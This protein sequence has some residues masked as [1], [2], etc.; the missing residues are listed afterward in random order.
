VSQ[1]WECIVDPKDL[2]AAGDI[3]AFHQIE[4]MKGPV[5][6]DVKFKEFKCKKGWRLEAVSEEI[7]LNEKNH[8]YR[9]IKDIEKDEIK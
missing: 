9:F 5:E 2:H 4:L 3:L 8:R 1:T 6:Y 7:I